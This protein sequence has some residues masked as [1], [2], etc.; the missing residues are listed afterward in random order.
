MAEGQ[1]AQLLEA[2]GLQAL[3]RLADA[4]TTKSPEARTL[5]RQAL[6][7][8]ADDSQAGL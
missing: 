8:L 2:G 6:K 1:R 3:L 4:D 7:R 5:A